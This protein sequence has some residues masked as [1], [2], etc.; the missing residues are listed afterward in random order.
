M[1]YLVPAVVVGVAVGPGSGA[2][3]GVDAGLDVLDQH[4]EDHM[5]P[6]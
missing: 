4:P 1:S 6:Q 3:L 2:I 5:A